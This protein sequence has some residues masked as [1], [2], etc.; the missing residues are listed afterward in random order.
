M[1]GGEHAAM[2]DRDVSTRMKSRPGRWLRRRREPA[3]QPLPAPHERDES[4]DPKAPA[5]GPKLDGAEKDVR[6]GRV[7]TDN[8]G[9]VR[10]SFERAQ[11]SPP[12]PESARPKRR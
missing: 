7:D 12:A 9:R 8:Y 4:V 10:E 2:S 6:E 3:A 1:A 11:E 5:A